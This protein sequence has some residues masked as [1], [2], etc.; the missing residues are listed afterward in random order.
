M[1]RKLIGDGGKGEG[2]GEKRESCAKGKRNVGEINLRIAEIETKYIVYTRTPYK[3]SHTAKSKRIL[4]HL[5]PFTLRVR[6]GLSVLE[7]IHAPRNH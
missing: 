5:S 1:I 3:K 4:S 7:V 6:K 2:E